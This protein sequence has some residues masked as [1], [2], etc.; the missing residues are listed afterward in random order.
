MVEIEKL[1]KEIVERLKP[2]KPQKIILFG[3]YAYGNPTDESDID[4]FIIKDIEPELTR[5]FSLKAKKA[6]REIIFREKIGIDIFVDSP[7]RVAK[8]ISE[9]KD[10]LYLQ[11]MKH[12]KSLYG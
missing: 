6:L 9:I 7:E 10:Q 5:E 4:L 1:K 2:F 3:S 12:G 8:R 11:I